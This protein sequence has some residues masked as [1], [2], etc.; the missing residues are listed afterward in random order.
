MGRFMGEKPKDFKS[1]MAKLLKLLGPYIPRLAIV[2]ILSISS[3]IVS[4]VAPKIMGGATTLIFLGRESQLAGGPGIDFAAVWGILRLLLV[5][6]VGGSL[7][8][9]ANAFL[10]SKVSNTIA[11]DLRNRMC[12]KIARLP[13]RYFDT[14]THGEILSRVTNDVS[15]VSMNFNMVL[16]QV[17][18]T[19]ISVVG[20][21]AMM[22]TI[23]VFMTIV[24][25]CV[26]PL[27]ALVMRL[28][29]SKS[30]KYFRMNSTYLGHVN[31]EIEEVF[32]G[33]VVVKAFNKEEDVTA[34]FDDLNNTL[35]TAGWRSQFISGFMMPVTGFIGNIAYV[36][37]SILG[38]YF[39][40]QGT[41]QVGEIQAFIQYVRQFNMPINQIAQIVNMMQSAAAAAERV[42]A[43]L[44]EEEEEQ[45]VENA[46]SP[47]GLVG[48]V[49]FDHVRFG[50]DESTVVIK[51]FSASVNAGQKIA[52]VGPTGA[53]KT[54]MVK[55]LMRFYDITSGGI[56]IDGHSIYE[57][58]RDKLRKVFG[59]VLQ[60]TWLFNGSIMENI[61][62]GRPGATDE[63]V[64]DAA[65]AA[66][67][68]H[69]IQTLP[70][71]YN[72]VLNE[73]ATNI[74]QGQRQLLTIARAVLADPTILILDEATSSVDTRT[75]VLIQVA[76]DGLMAGRTSFI[77]A[78]RLSTI[79]N[80]DLILVM[81][82][83]DIVEQGNHK[84]LLAAGGF[85]ATLYNSQFEDVA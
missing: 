82:H 38:G 28:I 9:Y 67:V 41:I 36:A 72:M 83:G 8:G 80:A 52:I 19:V 12:E 17:I 54:T 63:E 68:H 51:D 81:D 32:S 58:D 76:M 57:F 60:D 34:Q 66:Y 50:Y 59:M 6:H 1:T 13:M 69:F 18:N 14:K 77:I 42:F 78:H 85:Y 20:T 44:E 26:V 64:V 45:F 53:G 30:Q 56:S 21:L 48:N 25:V 65:K 24:T 15:Q 22:L 31:G 23:N 2:T 39:A 75:E 3:T 74:S 29:V 11:Y 46:I 43:L 79:K 49:V 61:R 55:L 33:H 37:M 62:Y 84:E 71:G 70:N 40:I 4:T 47:D 16:T 5:L 35:Y 10:M 7:F 73:D 27:S